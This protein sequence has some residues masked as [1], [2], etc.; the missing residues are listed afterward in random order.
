ML[1]LLLALVSTLWIATSVNA[2]ALTTT[3]APNEKLCFYADVDKAGEKIGVRPGAMLPYT[4]AHSYAT[5]SSILLCAL[6]PL[7]SHFA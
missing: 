4:I 7:L 1:R 6:C 3:I 5:Y 2:S